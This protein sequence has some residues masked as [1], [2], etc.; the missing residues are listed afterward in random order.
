LIKKRGVDFHSMRNGA[1]TETVARGRSRARLKRAVGRRNGPDKPPETRDLSEV[2]ASGVTPLHDA[3][4]RLQEPLDAI[5]GHENV[6]HRNLQAQSNLLTGKS[7]QGHEP[8]G[9]PRDRLEPLLNP[10]LVSI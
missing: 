5:L 1:G 4:F 3:N 2:P 8:E 9:I 7:L 10:F 6:R